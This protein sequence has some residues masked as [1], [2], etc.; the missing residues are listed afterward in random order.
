MGLEG[1]RKEINNFGGCPKFDTPPYKMLEKPEDP[2]C[3]TK[4]VDSHDYLLSL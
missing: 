4:V 2:C 1:I 3:D